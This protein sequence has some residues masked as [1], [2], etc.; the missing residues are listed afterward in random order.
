MAAYVRRHPTIIVG[1]GLLALMVAMAIFAP[2]LG[3]VD[4]QA[5]APAKRLKWPSAE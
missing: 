5:L 1:V 3:T 4:P 2:Y